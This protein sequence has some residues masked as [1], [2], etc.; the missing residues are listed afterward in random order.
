MSDPVAHRRSTCRAST[1][2]TR[3]A[4]KHGGDARAAMARRTSDRSRKE[5]G[6]GWKPMGTRKGSMVP[7]D[8]LCNDG[9]PPRWFCP[10][11]KRREEKTRPL[12]LFL[13]GLDGT[14]QM[15]APQAENLADRFEV[16]AMAVPQDSKASFQELVDMAV[17]TVRKEAERSPPERPVYLVGDS[18]GAV[19]AIEVAYRLPKHVQ[20]LVLVN[21]ATSASR[22]PW[23]QMGGLFPLLPVE[24]YEALPYAIA[25]IL[26][27]PLRVAETFSGGTLSPFDT[28]NA[29][30]EMLALAPALTELFPQEVLKHRLQVLNEGVE[31]VEPHIRDLKQRV[32][33]VAADEDRLLPSVEEGERLR[34]KLRTARLEKVQG[35]SHALLAEK[36]VNLMRIIEKASFYVE[37]R[38]LTSPSRDPKGP[39]GLKNLTVDIPTEAERR[40]A[41]EGG[42]DNLRR[43]TSPIYLSTT[44]EGNIVKG[45]GG[46]PNQRPLLF[47]GNHTLWAL[48]MG[49]MIEHFLSE[50][51]MLLRGLAH[52]A[53]FAQSGPES[54]GVSNV[55]SQFGA[56]QVSGRNLHRL[57]EAEEAVLLFPGGVREALKGRGEEYKLFWP[58]NA[59]FVRMAAKF[60]ATI[61]PF[62][63][64]GGDEIF[65]ILM[66]SK[67]VLN[68]PIIG[69][70]VRQRIKDLPN[71]R[72]AA[73]S[74]QEESFASPL[75]TPRVPPRFYFLY[76]KPVDM[77]DVDPNDKGACERIYMN[78]QTEIYRSFDYLLSKR[79]ADPYADLGPRLVYEA[80]SQFKQQAPTFSL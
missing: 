52:P 22:T 78:I 70:S 63:A 58:Q 60:D 54:G 49:M 72:S 42:V 30:V 27:N 7:R 40:Q 38:G 2:A 33:V 79:K 9:G 1:M 10:L 5:G 80:P 28:A 57:L 15:I 37:Q 34:R 53:L 23:T 11:V 74:R 20:R 32:L 47:V 62:A 29:L 71:A 18:F 8:Y 43:L 45:L 56:V 25:P 44:P 73:M 26:A 76:G 64:V 17:D 3:M 51:K 36:R 55:F 67:D 41:L 31:M 21:P 6:P 4:A 68:L 13:P 19:V 59:E 65:E 12:M 69:D 35:A 46:I 48:D 39:R 16:W 24:I 61:I 14:G 75:I 50:R 66:D 77:S